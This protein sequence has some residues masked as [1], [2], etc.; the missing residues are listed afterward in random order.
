MKKMHEKCLE[1]VS[2]LIGRFL[3]V[4]VTVIE[5]VLSKKRYLIFVMLYEK[6]R[7]LGRNFSNNILMK[8]L[9]ININLRIE[10]EGK[11]AIFHQFIYD[12]T[13]TDKIP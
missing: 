5:K 11:C 8:A 1:I 3:S 4:Y 7:Y 9:Q 12:I 2:E 10:I 6:P 13:N